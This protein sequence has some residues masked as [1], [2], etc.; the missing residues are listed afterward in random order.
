MVEVV[1]DLIEE[2]GV[3]YAAGEFFEYLIIWL[4][5]ARTCIDL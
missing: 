2:Y 5:M 1:A 3:E 4:K